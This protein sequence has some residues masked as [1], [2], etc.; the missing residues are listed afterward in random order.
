[1]SR[2]ILVGAAARVVVTFYTKV[3]SNFP[4]ELKSKPTKKGQNIIK[5]RSRSRL[6][7]PM[8]CFPADTNLVYFFHFSINRPTNPIT[9]ANQ[10]RV[11][12][13]VGHLADL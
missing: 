7:C 3:G 5:G 10:P 8:P 1:M 2:Y 11:S 6:K 13:L 9:A 12:G 4:S